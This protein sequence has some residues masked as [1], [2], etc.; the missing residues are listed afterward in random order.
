MEQGYNT[1][2]HMAI[3]HGDMILVTEETSATRK[4]VSQVCLKAISLPAVEVYESI[5]G[6]TYDQS[7]SPFGIC[8]ASA[9]EL[10]VIFLNHLTGYSKRLPT[11]ISEP[12]GSGHG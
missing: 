6:G 3:L 12:T 8:C 4:F 2:R 10:N 5:V 11:L 7:N 9:A 1:D